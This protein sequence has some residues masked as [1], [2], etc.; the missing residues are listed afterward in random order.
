MSTYGS[1]A[2]D[3]LGDIVFLLLFTHVL[4][5]ISVQLAQFIPCAAAPSESCRLLGSFPLALI[6][7]ARIMNGIWAMGPLF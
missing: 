2:G 7:S 3:P 5:H 6:P 4:K 1:K